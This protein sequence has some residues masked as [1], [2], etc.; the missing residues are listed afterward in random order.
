MSTNKYIKFIDT[1]MVIAGNSR[2]PM[3]SNKYSKRVYNQRQLLVLVLFKEY[4]NK[5][6]RDVVELVDLMDMHGEGEAK[7]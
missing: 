1:A 2:V 4:L 6:Y 5:D 7:A 3:Y